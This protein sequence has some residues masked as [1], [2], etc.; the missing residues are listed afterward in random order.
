MDKLNIKI[1]LGSIRE[2]RFGDKPAKWIYDIASVMPEIS[3][4]LLDLRDYKLPIF[5][6]AVSPAQVKGEYASEE[7]NVWAKKI[8][9]ADGFVIV[10]PEYNHG[11]TSALKNNMDYLYKE[12]NKKPVVFV[13]YGNSG[14]TRAVEQLRQVAIELQMAP[15]RNAVHINAPWNLVEPDGTLKAGALDAY[16]TSAKNMLDQLIWW[17][18][19][20]KVARG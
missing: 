14:G 18:K 13:A 5:A 8:A 4:E 6:E 19:A 20:L 2:N 12:W 17:T 9:E 11:Y 10:T 16:A 1:I 7:V 15:V 3:V